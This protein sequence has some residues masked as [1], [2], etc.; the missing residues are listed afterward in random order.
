MQTDCENQNQPTSFLL[1]SAEKAMSSE[2][3]TETEMM[4][5]VCKVLA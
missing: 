4:H 3:N 2:T 5:L 1:Q